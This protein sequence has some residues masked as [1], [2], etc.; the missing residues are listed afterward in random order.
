MRI[1]ITLH[2]R[3]VYCEADHK[4]LTGWQLFE[5]VPMIQFECLN[6]DEWIDRRAALNAIAIERS[7]FRHR[8]ALRDVDLESLR[9]HVEC[10]IAQVKRDRYARNRQHIATM[11]SMV[12]RPELFK[13]MLIARE[14]REAISE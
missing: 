3:S 13:P 4:L 2:R 12:D 7:Q 5:C 6:D 11:I 8:S 9:H 14:F 10:V 1:R